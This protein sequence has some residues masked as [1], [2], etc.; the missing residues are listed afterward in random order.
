MFDDLYAY[1]QNPIVGAGEP[2]GDRGV[3]GHGAARRKEV[4]A[5]GATITMATG[6]ATDAERN[7]RQHP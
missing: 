5:E 4:M 2:R 1:D 3:C 7:F 6:V